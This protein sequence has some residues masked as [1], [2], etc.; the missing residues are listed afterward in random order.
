MDARVFSVDAPRLTNTS[1]FAIP[2]VDG[3][4]LVGKLDRAGF[5][6]ASGSACSSANPEPSHTLL[7]MGVESGLARAAV[8]V[9]LGSDST[10][11]DVDGFLKA[12]GDNLASLRTLTAMTV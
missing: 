10:Q 2:G 6:V 4:T 5:A 11:Q 3:D 12:L 9:S 7:A 1:F 8:R